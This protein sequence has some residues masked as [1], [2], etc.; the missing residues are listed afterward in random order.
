LSAQVIEI[1]IANQSP[2]GNQQLRESPAN[3]MTRPVEDVMSV[4]QN[5]QLVEKAY[6]DFKRGHIPAMLE[7]L[8]EDVDWFVPGPA[9]TLPFV[10]RRRGRQQVAEFFA[11]L[12]QLETAQEFEPREFISQ[13]DK[14]VVLG[15]QRWIV[16]STRRT[17]EDNWAHVFTIR[18]GKI[19]QFRVYHDTH[20][21]AV[22]HNPEDDPS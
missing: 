18:N 5:T 19:A 21:E 15:Y 20:A 1:R 4:E 7:A 12:A 8:T 13:G 9:K 14:V 22:A 16:H 3:A 10:G 11:G 2:R 17:Y 6:A